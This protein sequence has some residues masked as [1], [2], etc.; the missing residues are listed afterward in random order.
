MANHACVAIGINRYHFLPPL[1]YGQADAQ[2][3]QHFFVGQAKL[4]SNRCLLLTDS[5]SAVGDVSTYPSRDNILR[6]LEAGSQHSW[7]PDGNWCWFFCSGYGVSWEG[8]DYL[9]PIDGNLDDI[10]GTAIPMRSLFEALKAQGSENL[11]VL[12][13][14][15]RSPGLQ[16]GTSVGAQTVELARQMDIALVLSSQL[17]EFSHEAAALGNGLFTAALLEALRYYHTEIT[18]EDLAQYLRVRLPELSQHHWRPIQT[19]LVLIPSPEARQQLIW[20]AA[21]NVVLDEQAA[22][23]IPASVMFGASSTTSHSLAETTPNGTAASVQNT[24]VPDGTQ[25][26]PR[27]PATAPNESASDSSAM[28]LHPARQSSTHQTPWWRA[29]LLWGGGAAL[30]LVLAIA[31]LLLRNQDRVTTQQAIEAPVTQ[32]SPT[33]IPLSPSPKLTTS[34]IAVLN[35]TP[36]PSAR[37]P[38]TPAPSRLQVNQAI[39][40]QAKAMLRSNQASM[41]SKAIIEARKIRPGDPLY[42]E[43]QQSITRWSEVILDLA[44]GRA[45]QGNY[46]S[47]IAAAQLVPKDNPSVYAK[48]QQILGQWKQM[49]TQQKQNKAIIQ[50]ARQQVRPNQASSY[51]RAIATLR[52]IPPNQPGYAEAQQLI[53]QASRTIYLIAQSRASRSRFQEAIQT[54]SLVPAGTPYS[55][56]SQKA[57]AKWKQGKR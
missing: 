25:E 17:D 52:K 21:D 47:A 38:L 32:K 26:L 22:G 50:T 51:N 33:P 28:I 14:I 46:S 3:V 18:L 31:S 53:A 11:L 45:E 5:S 7:Y 39:L 19:P 57:I 43:A 37:L 55:D 15:N 35:P 40:T 12:L 20:P 4:P 34:P 24:P 48:A 6:W 2:A 10:P 36:Q 49:A 56:A 29:L 41:F 13:D 23:K 16:A 30:V 44:E 9:L 54:A 8:V 27:I 1:S 42:Q